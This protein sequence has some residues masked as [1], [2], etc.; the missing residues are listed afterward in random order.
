MANYIYV[1]TYLHSS[2]APTHSH[3]RTYVHIPTH[4]THPH[5]HMHVNEATL[6]ICTHLSFS[7]NLMKSLLGGLGMRSRQLA[8]ESS[9][10]PIWNPVYGG[11][12]RGTSGREGRGISTG[13][14]SSAG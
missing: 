3:V 4:H 1:C 5:T 6:Y 13:G 14:K 11:V 10:E 8:R 7:M 9:S 12:S 2:P